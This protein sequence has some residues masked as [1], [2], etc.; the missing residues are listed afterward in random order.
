MGEVRQF[1][2]EFFKALSNPLR[3][4]ILDALRDGEH[5]VTELMV[6]LKVEQ[7]ALSQQLSVLRTKNLI[8]NRKEGSFVFY[9]VSD[10]EIF[11]LLDDA[12]KLF[13]NHLIDL[14]RS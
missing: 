7:S 4:A 14:H 12:W 11:R 10:P 2:A 6:A 13:Q 8:R 9:S 3:I 5:T 1:K